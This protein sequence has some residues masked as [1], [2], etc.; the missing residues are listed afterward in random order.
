MARYRRR[1][2]RR[3][4]WAV[5]ALL[6]VAVGTVVAL[7]WFIDPDVHRS[8]IEREASQILGRP[9]HL[10]HL[11]WHIGRRIAIESGPG[12]IDNSADFGAEP[13]ARWQRLRFDVALRPLLQRRV[14]IDR[15]VIEELHLDLQ[16][17]VSGAVNWQL[18]ASS[19]PAGQTEFAFEVG[20]V[21]WQ[22][23]SVRY[24]DARS[25]ADWRV[26]SVRLQVSLPAKVSAQEALLR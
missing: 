3:L 11:R 9:V 19:A 26:G 22:Q 23:G 13:M 14:L 25:G 21:E 15:V 10:T 18:P 16:R 5:A 24:R 6:A 12:R 2:I 17:N 8:R 7:L 1:L 4:L 20:Q